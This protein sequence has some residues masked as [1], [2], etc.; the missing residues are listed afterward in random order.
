M[1]WFRK[2]LVDNGLVSYY[3]LLCLAIQ[4]I[5][6]QYFHRHINYEYFYGQV[7]INVPSTVSETAD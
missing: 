7:S 6:N 5:D 4:P 2:E 1:Q 3:F